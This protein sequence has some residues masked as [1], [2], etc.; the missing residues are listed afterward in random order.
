MHECLL[1]ILK[2]KTRILVTHALNFVQIVDKI[3]LMEEG[4]ITESG[5]FD[6]IKNMK[7]F[8]I[9]YNEFH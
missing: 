9:I 5:T 8:M 4:T 2:N 1:G 3:Y 7:K 6:E